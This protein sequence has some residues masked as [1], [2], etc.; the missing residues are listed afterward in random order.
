M[1][2]VVIVSW[3]VRSYLHDALTSLLVSAQTSNLAQWEIIVVD[4][5]SHDG[6]V[7][8]VRAAFPM[9]RTIANTENLGFSKAN[10]Q[11]ARMARGEVVVF[12]NPDT[13]VPPEF[14]TLLH[15]MHI[16]APR[17]ISAPCLRYEDG[18]IQRSIKRDPTLVS[19]VCVLLKLHHI[20]ARI[21]PLR[22]YFALDFD[23]AQS[24]PVEQAMGACLI[25][26][27]S[28]LDACGGWPEE[29][30]LWWEDVDLC[31]RARALGFIIRYCP[32]L[33]ITHREGRSFAQR[34]SVQKQCMFI[35]GMLIYFTRRSQWY[36]VF[37]ILLVSPLSL[38]LSWVVSMLHIRPRGQGE[39][40]NI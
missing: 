26:P 5:A 3:N 6:T 32:D 27:R 22:N 34:K 36:T 21:P 14:F 20:S 16:R 18:T 33:V 9:V 8:H 10:N 7:E 31:Y 29:F 24:A 28:V 38:F 4:N 30:P 17:E 11:G 12:L 2:S 39:I 15:A 1:I 23:Y 40:K 35:R 37:A 19:Q 25:F 13:I